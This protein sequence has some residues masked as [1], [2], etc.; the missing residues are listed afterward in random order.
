VQPGETCSVMVRYA[1]GRAEVT[2]EE[3][4]VFTTNT[5]EGSEEVP[6]VATSTVLPETGPGPEGPAGPTGPE[7]PKGDTGPE[8]PKGDTGAPGPMGADGTNGATG[9]AGPKGEAGPNGATGPAG[10][11][12]SQGPKGTPGRDATVRCA[13]GGGRNAKGAKV[14]CKV[15]Y[16]A[17][18]SR[19]DARRLS[20]RQAK[21]LRGGKVVAK[22]TVAHLLASRSLEPG[23]YTM[24]VRTG[25]HQVTRLKVRVA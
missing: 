19:A 13:I 15:T 2:S 1:P 7:G 18:G 17:K 6:L 3:A 12:G 20:H 8:G 16:D 24:Q 5:A 14:T 21:L 11:L 22:G 4:L 25:S 23:V 9:P 10:P